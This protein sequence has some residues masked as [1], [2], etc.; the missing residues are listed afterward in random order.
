MKSKRMT[1]RPV[2]N[3]TD[4]ASQVVPVTEPES[5]FSCLRHHHSLPGEGEKCS[6]LALK[7]VFFDAGG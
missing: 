2:S 6:S 7:E 3:T 1:S 4:A 5:P